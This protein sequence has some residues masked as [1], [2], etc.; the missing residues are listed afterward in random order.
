MGRAALGSPV[1]SSVRTR[2]MPPRILSQQLSNPSGLLGRIMCR[3][4][5]RH[6]AAM[7]AFAL[8]CLETSAYDRVLEIGFGGGVALSPLLTNALH[9]TGVDRSPD[10]VAWARARY[11]QAVQDGRADFHVGRIESLPCA[12]ESFSQVL[13]VNTIYFWPSLEAGCAE[14]Y[15]VLGAG[16]RA[17]IGFLPK[18]RMDLLAYPHDIF[19]ARD[20]KDVAEAL[21]AAGLSDVRVE[22]PMRNVHWNVL[23]A[24][25]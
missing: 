13:T 16:G 8:Q 7:N 23:V 25:R 10:V 15:R 3:V 18:E 20:P 2:S 5:N 19:T 1:P 6:N 11:A 17:A 14:I 4:M 9:V 22:R 12:D 21:R 24:T